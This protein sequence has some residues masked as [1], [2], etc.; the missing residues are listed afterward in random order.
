MF[1]QGSV[2]NGLGYII[3][4]IVFSFLYNLTKFF[5]FQTVYVEL[6]DPETKEM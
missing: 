4:I 5:E 1:F 2:H 6:E 3:V